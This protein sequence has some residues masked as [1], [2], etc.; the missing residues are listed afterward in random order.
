MRCAQCRGARLSP[1]TRFNGKA[2]RAATRPHRDGAA[3]IAAS[4]FSI[5]WERYPA[6]SFTLPHGGYVE[7]RNVERESEPKSER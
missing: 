1:A 2:N 7:E 6:A 4:I 3:S 5:F